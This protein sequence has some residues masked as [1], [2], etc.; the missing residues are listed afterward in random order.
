MKLVHFVKLI[1][2]IFYVVIQTLH[3]IT[4]LTLN[5]NENKNRQ[6]SKTTCKISY[7]Y[8]ILLETLKKSL[9][10]YSCAILKIKCI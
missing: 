7:G 3:M 4:E 1:P 2:V 8:K 5:L 9:T 10:G 6:T